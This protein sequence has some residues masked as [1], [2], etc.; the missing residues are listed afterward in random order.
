MGL[1]VDGEWVDQWYDT[2]S[3]DGR[4]VR[5]TAG[6]RESIGSVA[7]PAESNRYHLYL[8]YAC[9]WAHR[10]AIF[11]ELKD[12]Q[13]HIS[14][15]YVH[16][17]MLS[18]GWEFDTADPDPHHQAQYLHQL[19]TLA[20]PN[21]SGRVTVPVL[22]DTKTQTIVCNE[23]SEIIRMLN[24]EFNHLT[25][26]LLDLYPPELR[27]DIDDINDFVYHRVNN[28]VYKVGFSTT[29]SVYDEEVAILFDA[30]DT[31]ESRL[32]SQRYLVGHQ[33][34]EADIRLFTTLLRFDPVYVGHFKCNRR[35]ISDY[36]N[37]SQYVRD[38]YQIEG[39]QSTVNMD[40]IKRHYYQ[41]HTMI[42]PTQVVPSGPDIDYL[43]PHNRQ[44]LHS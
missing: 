12:L 5:D 30:L 28:G 34:T 26:N 16:P 17:L 11:R 29:Q 39:I 10:T 42:N 31:L 37:L 41:S 38:I 22:W 2:K 24:S 36:P 6:F 20:K 4:F 13:S 19:Y 1:L 35:Q 27:S 40:H 7:Y 32:S 44:E 8:S 14:V 25:G 9:P 23:S 18:N 15:T 21:C 33:L 3:S 43:A